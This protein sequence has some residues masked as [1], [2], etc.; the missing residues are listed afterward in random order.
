MRYFQQLTRHGLPATICATLVLLTAPTAVADTPFDDF[1]ELTDAD[2]RDRAPRLDTDDLSP[3]L[4]AAD[5]EASPPEDP[6]VLRMT[7]DEPATY[8][9]VSRLQ[10]NYDNRPHFR[11]DYRSGLLVEYRPVDHHYRDRLPAWPLELTPADSTDGQPVVATVTDYSAF[12]AQ[13]PALGDPARMHSVL[14]DATFSY[15]LDDR[16]AIADLR[17]HPPTS[18]LIRASV[19]ELSHLLDATRPLLPDHPVE[20]G[21]TWTDTIAVEIADDDGERDTEIETRYTFNAW[22]PCPSGFCALIEVEHQFDASGLR[23]LINLQNHGD[24]RGA[25]TSRI[26]FDPD[27]GRVVSSFLETD[28]DGTTATVR[29]SDSE[30]APPEVLRDYQFE[31][32]VKTSMRLL[33]F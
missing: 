11:P 25:A 26:L 29:P 7:L 15:V 13:P 23:Q 19:E 33:D 1:P 22:Q 8:E 21:D 5:D 4:V 20:P 9:V 12:F 10:M 24:A 27:A 14:R 2:D 32:S 28:A 31:L 3:H 30:E 18:P 17:I 6:V 16:G